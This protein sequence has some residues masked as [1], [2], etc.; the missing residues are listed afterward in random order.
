MS[1]VAERRFED[2]YTE[3]LV[4]LREEY[5]FHVQQNGSLQQQLRQAHDHQLQMREH[6]WKEAQKHIDSVVADVAR[7]EAELITTIQ[8][9]AVDLVLRQQL[10][11]VR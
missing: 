6:Y 2:K 10:D 5:D 7:C 9:G 3:M 1:A 11:Q 4:R 8:S